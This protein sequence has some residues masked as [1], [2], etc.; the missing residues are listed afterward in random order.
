MALGERGRVAGDIQLGDLVGQQAV[1]PVLRD[2]EHGIQHDEPPGEVL[3]GADQRPDRAA[4]RVADDDV[5]V[6]A[7]L[8]QVGGVAA[9]PVTGG[10]RGVAVATEI[11]RGDV[12]AGAGECV[13]DPPPCR[14]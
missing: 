4:D 10:M 7:E 5:P 3:P 9:E 13:G 11:W 8:P 1:E 6:V 2:H 12:I 14:C